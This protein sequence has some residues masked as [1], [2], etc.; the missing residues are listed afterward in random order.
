[1]SGQV[2]TIGYYDNLAVAGMRLSKILEGIQTRK[3]VDKEMEITALNT[4]SRKKVENSLFICLSG[5]NVDSHDLVE[6]AVKNGAVAIVCE[7]E[8]DVR[9]PQIIMENTRSAIGNIAANFY[10]N[11]SKQLKIVGIT[12]TNGKTTTSY[13]LAK[14]WKKGGY[15]VGVIGTLGVSYAR[16]QLA[17]TLTTPDPIEL[18]H[19]LADMLICGI[20]Y[21]VMEV[22][23]HAIFYQ[24]LAGIRFAACIFTNLSQDHLDFFGTMQEYQKTKMRLFEKDCP[25]AIINGDDII[26]REI[27]K[28]RENVGLRTV[29]YGLNTPADCFAIVT[30]ERLGGTECMLNINDSLCRVRLSLTG[31]Y[32]VYNALAAAACAIE[33]G[34]DTNAVANGLNSLKS[35]C[36]RLQKVGELYGANIYV[37][38]AHTPDGLGK[39]L[40]AL[41]KHCKGRLICLFGCGGNRDKVKRPIM[42]EIAAK[43]ADFAVLTSDNPRYE[44]PL[45]IIADIERGY[46]RF[47]PRYVVV[48]DRQRAIDYALEILKREDVLLIAGKGGEE[49]QEIMGIK[50]PFSDHTV[51][52]RLLEQKGKRPCN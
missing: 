50:Y 42:G 15:K 46:R 32:N 39:S 3:A 25:L 17:A 4:D 45:D 21:V 2:N 18:Q 48:P 7:R 23:A 37:D 12:G 20:E 38:F 40:D 11:P 30:D 33:L 19:I 51:V 1:M 29:Y 13:M 52:E 8:L 31:E 26:G 34:I 14:I 35:V 41:K 24:K 10:G 5:K 28:L 44:D 36:G 6:E 16:K 27:G 43:K 49:Y 9:V 22:S 47:S